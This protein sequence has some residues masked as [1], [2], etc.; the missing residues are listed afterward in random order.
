VIF[1][2]L[3]LDARIKFHGISRAVLHDAIA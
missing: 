2:A 3:S 1:D